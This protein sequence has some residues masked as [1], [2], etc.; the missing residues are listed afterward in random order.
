MQVIKDFWKSVTS[1]KNLLEWIIYMGVIMPLGIFIEA[2]T[3]V[4]GTL[5][6][7]IFIVGIALALLISNRIVEGIAWK[8]EI[9]ELTEEHPEDFV[10]VDNA[11]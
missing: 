8:A 3:P 10:D 11:K 4:T 2:L 7:V 5:F 6:W 1:P 9:P